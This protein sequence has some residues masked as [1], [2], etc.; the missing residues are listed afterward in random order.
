MGLVGTSTS[1]GLFTRANGRTTSSTALA[2]KNGLT[3][4]VTLGS[5]HS[6]RSRAR[7]FTNGTT[8]ASTAGNG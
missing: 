1:T 7:V 2:L 5:T 6:A 4:Q 8:A 3:V